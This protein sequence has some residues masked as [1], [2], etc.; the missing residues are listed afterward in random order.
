LE[1]DVLRFTTRFLSQFSGDL[2]RMLARYLQEFAAHRPS[3][4]V[5]LWSL[6][7]LWA[8]SRGMRGARKGLDR[9]FRVRRRGGIVRTKLSDLGLTVL[10]LGVAGFA[11]TILVGGQQL[12]EAVATFFDL[13]FLF[14]RTWA[15]LRWPVILASMLGM[16]VLAYRLLPARKVAWRHLFAGAIPAVLGWI[17]LGSGF[18]I[19]LRL[20]GSFDK[21]YGSLA[22]FFLL[23]FLLW[24]VS[25]LLLLGGEIAARL[26]DR[27]ESSPG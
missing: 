5:L 15:W 27:E 23:M 26:A 3:G 10:F 22:S 2:S 6:A 14:T 8:A 4:G 24:L 13:G 12:G 1:R 9:V 11:Y 17:A 16:T 19:W 18:R 7:G 25:L 20:L 21:L